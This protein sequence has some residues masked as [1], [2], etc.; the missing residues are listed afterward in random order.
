MPRER[1]DTGLF[2]QLAMRGLLGAFV[3]P[4][5]AAWE[6]P[7]VAVGVL[8]PLYEQRAE[9]ALP[10]GEDGQINGYANGGKSVGRYAAR[11][12]RSPNLAWV[13]T[14]MPSKLSWCLIL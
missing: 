11:Y 6:G 7:A 9:L 5:E 13:V 4:D 2:E 10:N 3:G 8:A 12:S 14:S 1:P